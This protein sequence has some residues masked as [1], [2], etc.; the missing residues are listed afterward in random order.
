MR[1]M[2]EMNMG[3]GMNMFGDFGMPMNAT[4][5]ANHPLISKIVESD[6]EDLKSKM[7]RQAFDLALLSQHKLEGKALTDFITRTLELSTRMN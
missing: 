2:K 4:I 5:N 6:S 1:R 7:A 3:R